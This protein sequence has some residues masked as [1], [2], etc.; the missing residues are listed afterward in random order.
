M[1]LPE[2]NRDGG[3]QPE[4]DLGEQERKRKATEIGKSG[5]KMVN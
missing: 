3:M 4:M 2:A 5:G 1:E